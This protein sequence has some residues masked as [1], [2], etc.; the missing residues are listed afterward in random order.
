MRR[1]NIWLTFIVHLNSH[2]R[3]IVVTSRMSFWE[4]ETFEHM[5]LVVN[6][7]RF[8]NRKAHACKN[9]AQFLNFTHQRMNRTL[10]SRQEFN[11]LC[12]Y[13]PGC[14]YIYRFDIRTFEFLFS[15]CNGFLYV[16]FQ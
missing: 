9:I 2:K 4:I 5:V 6:L 3:I 16:S 12:I 7:S 15:L 14:R 1:S 8:L 11:W 13:I 10:I